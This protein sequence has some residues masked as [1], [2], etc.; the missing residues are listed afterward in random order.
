MDLEVVLKGA[1]PPVVAAL[2]FVSL[3]GARLLPLA[4]GVGLLVAYGL[5]RNEVPPWPH[6]LWSAPNGAAWLLWGIVFAGLLA[7]LEHLR[8]VPQRVAPVLGVAA[9]G[10]VVWLMLDKLAARWDAN[11]VLLHV[12]GGAVLAGAAVLA[13]RR[14]LGLAPKGLGPAIVV[15]LL[16]SLD[17]GLVALAG[18]SAFLGQLCGA[19]A[20][21][22]GAACGTVLWR[23]AFT[24]GVADGTW[25]GITQV[26]FVLAGV[27]L[28]YLPWS[29]A[30][31]ALLP[32]F[33]LLLVPRGLATRKPWAWTV[34]AG[35]LV[36][37]PVVAAMLLAAPM[38]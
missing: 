23:R 33:T 11:D 2:L 5:L 35:V 9:A 28:A 21:A 20:G 32:P 36:L 7:L 24:L 26:G 29:L 1:L 17:A 38:A 3:G 16:L 25:I 27:H 31:L 8:L 34:V 18:R 22:V 13:Q 12:G 15:M 14:G 4:V 19:V 6:E 37:G 10:V 30:A